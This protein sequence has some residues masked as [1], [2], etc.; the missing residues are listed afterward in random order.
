MA[1][2]TSG[3]PSDRLTLVRGENHCVWDVEGRRYFDALSGAF[4]VQLG[5]TRPDLLRAMSDAAARLPFARATKFESEESSGYARELLAAAGPH[6]TSVLFTSSGSEAVDVAL[7]VAFRYQRAAGRPDRTGIAHL[8]GH[9][10]GATL[11]ALRV[12]DYRARR[13]AY[14]AML[15][16]EPVG[17]SAYCKRCFRG[18]SFPSCDLAC[19]DAA[20]A[21][22]PRIDA[23]LPV[24][25]AEPAAII[26][27]TI[28]AAGLGA[29]VPPP[30]Y[31]ARIRHWCD[32]HGALWIA[33]EV[34]TGFGRVGALFAWQRL[35][36]R[37]EELGATPDVAVFGKGAGAGFAPLGGVLLSERVAHALDTEP[38]AAFAHAQ[39]YGGNPI[40]C[41]VGR[42]VLAAIR[43]ERVFA[44]VRE[45]ERAL[46]E[47]L[48]PL[49]AH[50]HVS[51]LRG[52]GFLWGVE[53]VEDR[54]SG[55][56][57]PRASRVAERLE[58]ACRERGVLIYAGTGCA[59][60]ERGDFAL[61]APPLTADKAAFAAIA[62]ALGDAI[63]EVTEAGARK[64]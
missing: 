34:L 23:A 24:A 9:Y 1:A 56:S 3:N 61:I 39:T 60:G 7:K 4:C 31:L 58:A 13:E 51:D 16:R 18:L 50:L 48:R 20:F 10:H 37:A 22:E 32:L 62:T 12:T 40:A 8:R 2:N 53:I 6:F 44:H 59:D 35:A 29:P 63:C 41:A 11:G 46:H 15:G 47:A 54:A 28:P 45:A 17:P 19:A 26:L 42:R 57:F 52:L 27:E 49:T 25:E 33:D 30:G 36:E 14:D 21:A 5:Y 38:G 64:G 55:R 43:E